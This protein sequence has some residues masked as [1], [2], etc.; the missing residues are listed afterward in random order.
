MKCEKQQSTKK[1][2][3]SKYNADIA[4]EEREKNLFNISFRDDACEI[5]AHNLNVCIRLQ[6]R[7]AAA[8]EKGERIDNL[9]KHLPIISTLFHI[10]FT[11]TQNQPSYMHLSY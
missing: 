8:E 2:R 6:N 9:M 11:T 10:Y 7:I 1:Y 4:E 3:V 5:E